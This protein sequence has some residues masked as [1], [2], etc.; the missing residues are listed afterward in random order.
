MDR[1]AV[2][3]L[4]PFLTVLIAFGNM[5]IF[6]L[7]SKRP[8]AIGFG[9]FLSGDG[10]TEELFAAKFSKMLFACKDFDLL[11]LDLSKSTG[12]LA[13][14][15][16]HVVSYSYFSIVPCTAALDLKGY[17]CTRRRGT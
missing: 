14:I 10:L 8:R 16:V 12:I 7:E 6:F 15:K 1:T 11:L 9:H 2:N 3:S 13:S 5:H 4:P 17:K